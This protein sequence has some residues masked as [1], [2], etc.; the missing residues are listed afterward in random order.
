VLLQLWLKVGAKIHKKVCSNYT[1]QNTTQ[2]LVRNIIP[3]LQ[4]VY[5]PDIWQ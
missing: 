2:A 3:F 4:T 5:S 1:L